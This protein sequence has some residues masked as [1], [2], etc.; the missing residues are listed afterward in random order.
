MGAG[1]KIRRPG[2]G[3]GLETRHG[4][5]C[6]LWRAQRRAHLPGKEG[7]RRRA[8]KLRRPLPAV[9]GGAQRAAEAEAAAGEARKKLALSDEATAAFRVRFDVWQR[10]FL[11]LRDALGRV[12]D[13]EKR[14]K[15]GM[16][17]KAA[18]EKMGEEEA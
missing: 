10:D 17:V 14:G 1:T 18:L 11:A 5:L 7:R 8:G 9:S 12:E 6:S 4:A 2:D 15:L 13:T 16:A 3:R